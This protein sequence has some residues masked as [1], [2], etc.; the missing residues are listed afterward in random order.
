MPPEQWLGEEA[1][2]R[3]DLFSLGVVAY[4][5]FT[6]QRPFFSDNLAALGLQILNDEPPPV[7]QLNRSFPRGVSEVVSRAIAKK[8]DERYANARAMARDLE[9]VRSEIQEAAQ[10]LLEL[11]CKGVAELEGLV[12]ARRELFRAGLFESLVEASGSTP[13]DAQL[14]QRIRGTAAQFTTNAGQ[15]VDYLGL[16]EQTGQ[17]QSQLTRVR[18]LLPRLER[19]DFVLK[20]AEVEEREGNF[21]GAMRMASGILSDLPSWKEAADLLERAEKKLQSEPP[22]EVEP[23][24]PGVSRPQPKDS[25]P[26]PRRGEAEGSAA[27]GAEP[28]AAPP[29][30]E[31]RQRIEAL[32]KQA[33]SLLDARRAGKEPGQ[34]RELESAAKPEEELPG[35]ERTLRATRRPAPERRAA[36]A[37]EEPKP[38]E[39]GEIKQ[40]IAALLEEARRRMESQGRTPRRVRPLE[41][42]QE[43]EESFI[44]KRTAEPE[45]EEGAEPGRPVETPERETTATLRASQPGRG[46]KTFGASLSHALRALLQRGLKLWERLVVLALWSRDAWRKK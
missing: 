19:V 12:A 15:N 16:I 9:R 14:L 41:Q 13:E 42:D 35:S 20:C 45:V 31:L 26:A 36:T 25:S 28:A 18:S 39:R 4:E 37:R 44:F 30:E 6:G 7:D 46:Q 43:P 24:L 32:L 38:D 17:I 23:G 5:F 8:R 2:A 21:E 40:R 11:A 34:S 3:T 33:K 1:D 27:G 29:E 22:S 10:G